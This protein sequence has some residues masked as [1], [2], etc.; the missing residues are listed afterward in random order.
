MA[1]TINVTL[2]IITVSDSATHSP[3][4]IHIMKR[5]SL[6]LEESMSSPIYYRSTEGWKLAVGFNPVPGL[7]AFVWDK[8]WIL[9]FYEQF[10]LAAADASG[11]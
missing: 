7:F 2:E 1:T 8:S 6:L 9:D 4:Q 11:F 3:H 10:P 5:T